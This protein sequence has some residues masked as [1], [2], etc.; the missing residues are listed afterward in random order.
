M[1]SKELSSKRGLSGKI[2]L[3]LILI[4][5]NTFC[6]AQSS[7][8]E[9]KNLYQEQSNLP[10]DSLRLPK[11]SF[12]AI[13]HTIE[14]F[15]EYY[16]R[17]GRIHSSKKHA[18]E[19]LDS[20]YADT[21]Y[22]Y[23]LIYTLNY[24]ISLFKIKVSDFEGI[25]LTA[26]DGYRLRTRFVDE[27]IPKEDKSKVADSHTRQNEIMHYMFRYIYDKNARTIRFRYNRKVQ[28]KIGYLI[29][30]TYMADYYLKEDVFRVPTPHR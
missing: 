7:K 9:I 11:Y 10:I 25:S 21:K 15:V 6:N 27:I 28:G 2:V 29:N 20:L 12:L 1:T 4:L 30:K 24:P 26:L 16:I 19:Y 22:V 3:A 17:H 18:E 8:K 23:F 14:N 13:E 5:I